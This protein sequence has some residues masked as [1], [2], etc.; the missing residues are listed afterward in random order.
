M[1]RFSV[2]TALVGAPRID[3]AKILVALENKFI[4]EEI[5]AYLAGFPVLG[6]Q[7]ELVSRLWYGE[8][9][10]ASAVFYGDIDPS[11]DQPWETPDSVEV[12]RDV[13]AVRLDDYAAIVMAANYTS[14]RLRYP[15]D[16]PADPTSFNPSSHVQSAPLPRL[17]ADAMA[18]KRLVKGLLCH[19]LWILTPNPRLLRG[20]KVICHS[21]VM[22]DIM[23]CGAEIVLTPDRVVTDEDL[24]TGF[25]KHEVLPFIAAIARQIASH[26][27]GGKKS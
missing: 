1:T 21:V 19:G 8:Y 23:N 18:D 10:P 9:R 14:V 12:R 16:L 2:Q 26:S 22:A 3:G 6:A 15:G 11:D 24:V 17:F 4:P 13:S 25:S 20:R 27:N 5:A 7:V